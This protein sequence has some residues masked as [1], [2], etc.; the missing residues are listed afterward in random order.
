MAYPKVTLIGRE[1][2]KVILDD[3]KVAFEQ[4][5]PR[6]DVHPKHIPL[7]KSMK[8]TQ[9]DPMF[10]FDHG[11]TTVKVT[12]AAKPKPKAKQKA[13]AKVPPK[14]KAKTVIVKTDSRK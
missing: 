9:D 3:K 7:L 13:K 6:D 12:A 10:S 8:T 4:G 2:F 1:L 14:P 11:V 5:V